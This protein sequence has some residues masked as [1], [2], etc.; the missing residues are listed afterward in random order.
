LPELLIAS[1]LEEASLG[2][3]EV[4]PFWAFGLQFGVAGTAVDLGVYL[5]EFS[6]SLREPRC[7]A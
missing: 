1:G 3:A 4:R 6:D 5:S 2:Y 7:P